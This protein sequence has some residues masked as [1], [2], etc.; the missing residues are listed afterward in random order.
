MDRICIMKNIS[1]SGTSWVDGGCPS[2][3]KFLL[4]V[5]E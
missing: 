2:V 5:D 4:L 3:S 1:V